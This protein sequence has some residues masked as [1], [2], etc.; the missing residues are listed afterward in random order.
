MYS[1]LIALDKYPGVRLVG[2][3]E[4]WRRLFDKIVLNLMGP[5]SNMVCQGDQMCAG[6]KAGIDRA[7]HRLQAL[8]DENS[9][10]EEWGF[11]LV[12][13]K[14]VFNDINRVVML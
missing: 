7:I 10:T 9:S 1:R 13:A 5:E 6:R 2:V 14:N 11:L 4:M 12:E 8:W 3:G